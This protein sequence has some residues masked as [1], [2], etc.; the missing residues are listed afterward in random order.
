[1]AVENFWSSDQHD[2]APLWRFCNRLYKCRVYLLSYLY[3]NLL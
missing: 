2:L 3:T 1:V